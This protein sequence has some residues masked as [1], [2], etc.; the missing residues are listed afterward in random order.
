MVNR[1][2]EMKSRTIP[3]IGNKTEKHKVLAGTHPPPQ[4]KD[5][6]SKNTTFNANIC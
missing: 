2:Y 3:L 4:K 5:C 1:S 6:T